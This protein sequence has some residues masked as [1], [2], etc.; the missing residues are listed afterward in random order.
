MFSLD[1]LQLPWIL[2]VPFLPVCVL[3]PVC[4]LP[5]PSGYPYLNPKATEDLQD[6]FSLP[7]LLS[8]VWERCLNRKPLR[9]G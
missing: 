3:K 8:L 9:A 4:L 5:L 7:G 1:F 2:L 6:F